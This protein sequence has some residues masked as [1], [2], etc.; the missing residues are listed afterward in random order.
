MGT[1]VVWRLE[2]ALADLLAGFFLGCLV[3]WLAVVGSGPN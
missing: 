2:V 1:R 3:L